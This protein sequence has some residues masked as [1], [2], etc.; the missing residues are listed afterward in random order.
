MLMLQLIPVGHLGLVEFLT[1]HRQPSVMR[2]PHS[3]SHKTRRCWRNPRLLGRRVAGPA[4]ERPGRE[5]RVERPHRRRA[6]S[7]GRSV[8]RPQPRGSPSRAS[9]AGTLAV[10][11]YGARGAGPRGGGMKV[12]SLDGRQ[13]RKMLRKEAA[14]RCVVLDCRPY[15]AFAASSVRG[16]LN[17]NL[18]SV[19]LRRARGGAVSARYVLPDEAARARLLQEGGGGPEKSMLNIYLPF[20]S[21]FNLAGGYETFY[22]EYPECCVDVQPI[23]QEKVETEK[24]LMSQCGKPVLSL[25]YRP[26]YDQGG[27]V[28]I[29]PFLYLGSAYHASKCEFLA[30]LHITALLNV[31]RRISESCTTHLHYKWIPVE[32]SHTAD[33]SSHFQEAIDFIDCVREKGGKVLVHCEAGISRSPTICMAYLMKAKQFRLKDAFDYIKQ[34]RSVVSPNFGFMGQ[35]LQY[36]SEILPSTP[37]APSCQGEAA[38]SSFIAHLQTL[39]PD[40]QGSYCTFPTSV[41][42]PV[43]TH[44]TVSELGRSPMATA[45]SC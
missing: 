23:S 28:E 39:S 43:P 26:A 16:S 3:H 44:S 11:T 45:T 12:T 19:V 7:V 33:I 29:L 9:P 15:L 37:Q 34:R 22:S 18:N 36:E 17:V 8:G 30:N 24:A 31:S 21:F 25:S 41:L 1:P 10:G 27:P 13:L 6:R 2:E 35:L 40:L 38:S 32:D 5:R 14:A 42:A 4:A 20:F